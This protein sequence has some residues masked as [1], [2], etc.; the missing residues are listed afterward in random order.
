MAHI[1]IHQEKAA[2]PAALAAL[3]PF[4]A[5]RADGGKL[6]IDAGC[7]M[8]R[9]CIRRGNGVF[10]YVE[11]RSPSVDKSAWR[12]IAVI[13]EQTAGTVHPVTYELIGKARELAG[14]TGQTVYCVLI[15]HEVAEKA[16][17][18]LAYG[19][20]EVFVYD[21]PALEHFRIEP[22]AAVLEEFINAKHPSAVLV[23]GTPSGRSLAPRAA[24][25]FRTGLTADCTFLDMQLNTDL[26]QIRPAYGGNIMAHINTPNHRPQFATVRYK[27]F[28]I[29]PKGAASG[30]SRAA[31]SRRKSSRQAFRSSGW[32]KNSAK[33]ASRRRRSSSSP[34][35]ASAGRRTLRCLRNSP[36]CSGENSPR[37]V[38][39]SKR[40]GS[41]RAAR[42]GSRADGQ[43]E[44]HHHL[45]R[46]GG[47]PV[48]RRHERFGADRRD[49]HGPG[50]ADF[51]G[52][53]H[54]GIRGDLYQIVPR[55]IEKIKNGKG[56]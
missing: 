22:Y 45:R 17:E 5:I 27:I 13:A 33:P 25:R 43:A 32:P 37:P 34:D 8:C 14:K 48:R 35:A 16:D 51:Q 30:R 11:D 50:R 49:Q 24:A 52:R 47:D 19:A 10:E 12:G 28:S 1:R 21:D 3:C 39:S 41:I 29:P 54:R 38:R 56:R 4:G 40:A 44:A 2:D 6:D 53:A 18:L 42:S 26:D 9:I 31:P 7:K 46:L 15:G 36:G 20:D 23:G 55:L